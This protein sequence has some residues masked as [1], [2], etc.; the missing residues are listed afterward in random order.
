MNATSLALLQL[1]DSLGMRDQFLEDIK[2]LVAERLHYSPERVAERYDVS[3]SSIKSWRA[4]GLLTPSLKIPDGTAR[5]TLKDFMEFERKTGK[6]AQ[7]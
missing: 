3:L 2:P 6:K 4:K 5:Y 7:S 1:A